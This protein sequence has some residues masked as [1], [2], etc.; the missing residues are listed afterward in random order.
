V[1]HSASAHICAHSLN[2]PVL[3]FIFGLMMVQ[4]TET[5]H[6]IFN[7]D[8][9]YMLCYWLN[10]LLYYCKTQWDDSYK[11]CKVYGAQS[12]CGRISTSDKFG[13]P[14]LCLKR[15]FH[16]IFLFTYH[17]CHVISKFYISLTH[18]LLTWRIWRAPNNASR[19]QMGF[20]SAFK[21]LK[22]YNH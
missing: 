3:C 16:I 20:N 14:R 5:R 15:V 7:I 22:K 13:F 9:Q 4:W 18:I 21:W 19:W 11:K 6:R 12:G 17:R 8:Y 2:V 10:K 1:V